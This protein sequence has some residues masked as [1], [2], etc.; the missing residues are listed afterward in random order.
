[1]QPTVEPIRAQLTAAQVRHLIQGAPSVIVGA[2]L[3]ATNL[4]QIEALDITDDFLGGTVERSMYA[5]LHGSATLQ[6]TRPLEWGWQVVKPYM[7]ITDGQRTAR[8]NLGAYF[9]N[10]PQRVTGETP[11]TWEVS[12]YDLLYRLD[13]TVGGSYSVA[14]GTAV[15]GRVEEILLARGYTLYL[16]DQSR[17]DAVTPD[18]KTWAM[19]DAV[20]WLSIVNDLLGMV[21]YQGIWSDWNGYLRCEPY[22]RPLDRNYEWYLGAGAYSILDPTAQVSFDYHDAYN[23]W[24]GIRQ[25]N[26]EDA[27]PVEGSGV[28]TLENPSTGPTSIDARDGMVNTR[29]E[30]FDIVSQA[31][32][33]SAV[34]SMADADMSIPTTI[35]TTTGPLPLAWHFDRYM[36]DNPDVGLPSDV[37]NTSWRLPLN[38][39]PMEHSWTV[40]AGVRS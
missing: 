36:L 37:L 28:Y 22:V 15:L 31:D 25:N 8:F 23:R 34:Q 4:A 33:I 30:S 20:S 39:D 2:G 40:L 14:K 12:C 7:T 13:K 27:A 26:P 18:M 38:G 32:L 19:D 1:M 35:A 9:T 29:Q 24:V 11:A 3:E 21:G 17:Y 16:I 10:T 6:V 5:T